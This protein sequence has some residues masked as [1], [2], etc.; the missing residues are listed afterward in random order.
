MKPV[1][2]LQQW[3]RRNYANVVIRKACDRNGNPIG[4]VIERHDGTPAGVIAAARRV[5]E[6]MFID[7]PDASNVQ[8]RIG[9]TD[10]DGAPRWSIS[11][12]FTHLAEIGTDEAEYIWTGQMREP[13]IQE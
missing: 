7:Y 3:R 8:S 10:P 12:N 1:D 9:A 6:R 5:S 13:S 4:T 11:P 2:K